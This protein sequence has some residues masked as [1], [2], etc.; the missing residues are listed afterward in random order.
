MRLFLFLLL[1]L[2]LAQGLEQVREYLRR[3]QYELALTRLQGLPPGPEALA[4]KGRA[5]LLLGNLKE[6]QKALEEAD[7]VGQGVEGKR[8]RGWLALEGGQHRTAQ[9]AFQAAAMSS[10]LFQDALLWALAV[11]MAGGPSEE[12][13]EKAE[14]A[15]GKAEAAFLRGL[16]LL[17]RDPEGALAA[18]QKA[19]EG[20]FK[21][22][23]LYFQGRALEA[24]GRVPEARQLYRE[25]LRLSPD[26]LPARR[27]LGLMK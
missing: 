1:G 20:P 11:Q 23:A 3:G 25:A 12:A 17:A 8:L 18:F 19:G 21:V 4:L 24:L 10:G 9:A 14:K 26:Y 2:A 27:V 13:L 6:A 15:G 16:S 5:Y 7:R 22:Q